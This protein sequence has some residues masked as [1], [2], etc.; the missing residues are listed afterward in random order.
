VPTPS[1]PGDDPL[2]PACT[3]GALR[4]AWQDIQQAAHAAVDLS[5]PG[6]VER[7]LEAAQ[8]LGVLDKRLKC[9]AIIA[10]VVDGHTWH[11][12]G[13][14]LGR[15]AADAELLYGQAVTRWLEGDPEPWAPHIHVT[16][17]PIAT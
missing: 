3:M 2:L 8:Q 17:Y 6:G 12:V 15:T 5:A 13:A 10:L 11:D 1:Q 7:L 4:L 14:R 9:L 16:T